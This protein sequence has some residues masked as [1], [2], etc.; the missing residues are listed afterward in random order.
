MAPSVLR[1]WSK[2]A[3]KF[4]SFP[5]SARQTFRAVYGVLLKLTKVLGEAGVPM[6]AGTESGGAA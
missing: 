2:A 5:T 6:L 1:G 4:S 3:K